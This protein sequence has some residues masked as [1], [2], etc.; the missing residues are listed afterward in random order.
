MTVAFNCKEVTCPFCDR[1]SS[2]IHFTYNRTFQDLPIQ[3][4]KVFII[5]CNR[6]M[7][8]DNSDCKHT[9]FAE[10]FDFMYY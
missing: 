7:F 3:G 4:N 8:C 9:T 2:R 10:R 6:K 1:P 5:I